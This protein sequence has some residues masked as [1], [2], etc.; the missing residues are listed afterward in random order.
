MKQLLQKGLFKNLIIGGIL[1]GL[2]QI[3]LSF[4]TVHF[5]RPPFLFPEPRFEKPALSSLFLYGAN[6]N[7]CTGKNSC[8]AT[9]PILD[10]YGPHTIQAD[11]NGVPFAPGHQVSLN[12]KVQVFEA[13]LDWYQNINRGFFIQAL[14]PFR[15]IQLQEATVH[16]ITAL[17]LREE[18]AWQLFLKNIDHTLAQHKLT[19]AGYSE[20]GV[21]D[22]GLALG[23]TINYEDTRYLDF[24]DATIKIGVTLPIS[25]QRGL[26]HVLEIPLGY[27]GHTGLFIEG[28]AS[29]GLYDWITIACYG[30]GIFFNK[31]TALERVKTNTKQSGLLLFQEELVKIKRGNIA[32]AGFLCKADHVIFGLSCTLGYQFNLQRPDHWF[33]CSSQIPYEFCDQR[34]Q[35]FTMNTF[36]L[37][38]EY[39]FSHDDNPHAPIIGL[40]Y[41]KP[42]GGKRCFL[43]SMLGGFLGFHLSWCY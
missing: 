20:Q 43:P 12:S 17:P 26:C 8:G 4:D 6:G 41:N 28:E 19:R 38:I 35:G 21:G 7:S 34:L 16:D 29:I 24:I 27:N 18:P 31:T 5:F 40:I 23:W 37:A 3:L 22:A 10:I 30:K 32:A 33:I 2:P 39:D 42:T 14:V 11:S 15:R 36:H 9:V 25:K 1:C 13:V